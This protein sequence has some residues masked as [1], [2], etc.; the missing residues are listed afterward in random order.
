MNEDQRKSTFRQDYRIDRI[1]TASFMKSL[2]RRAPHV[3]MAAPGLRPLLRAGNQASRWAPGFQ[4]KR[5]PW[6][7]ETAENTTV[8]TGN[9]ETRIGQIH[10][11]NRIRAHPRN[12]CHPCAIGNADGLR[13]CPEAANSNQNQSKRLKKRQLL[14]LKFGRPPCIRQYFLYFLHLKSNYF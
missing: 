14:N 7:S 13:H 10:T 2:R 5:E 12:P 4:R 9:T 3:P 11:D 6:Q 1:R 8:S